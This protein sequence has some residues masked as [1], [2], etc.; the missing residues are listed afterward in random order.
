MRL[1]AF[2]ALVLSIQINRAADIV[3]ADFEGKDYGAW[4]T[5]GTAFGAG[6]AQ[7]A[8]P[9]QMAVTGYLGHGL[10]NSYYDGDKSTGTLTSPEF[11][12]CPACL[13]KKR[14]GQKFCGLSMHRLSAWS[15]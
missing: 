12:N 9:Q 5:T 4:T 7:G 11:K 15:P 13:Q 1:L 14:C 10:A 3:L 8:S 2:I 6:P